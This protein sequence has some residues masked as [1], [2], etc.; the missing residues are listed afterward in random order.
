MFLS[1][2]NS[3]DLFKSQLVPRS[4]INP[5]GRRTGMSGDPLCDLDGAARTAALELCPWAP[6]GS[7]NGGVAPTSEVLAL[8]CGVG[9]LPAP[10][11]KRS[12]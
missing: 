12:R 6:G 10:N 1:D 3:L 8:L 4:I 11:L 9:K 5:G 7:W 2:L